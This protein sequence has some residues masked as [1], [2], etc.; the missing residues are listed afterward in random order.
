MVCNAR[1]ALPNDGPNLSAENLQAD[2]G[3]SGRCLQSAQAAIAAM[4]RR[5]QAA[6][7][8]CLSPAW[9]GCA[10]QFLTGYCHQR[11]GQY[12]DRSAGRCLGPQNIRVNAVCPGLIKPRW[13]IPRPV[14][15]AMEPMR[16]RMPLR[17][18][19]SRAK[20]GMR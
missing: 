18:W 20:W 14:A 15:Q 1:I 7:A 8:W 10:A 17:G 4:E 19:A 6:L 12:A 13:S 5:G 16:Q 9:V 3:Q 11:R 2:R